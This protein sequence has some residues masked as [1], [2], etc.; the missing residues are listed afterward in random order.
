[1]R[2]LLAGE[3]PEMLSA[4]RVLLLY[5]YPRWNVQMNSRL[6]SLARAVRAQPCDLLIFDWHMVVRR[7]NRLQGEM[8]FLALRRQQPGLRIIVLDNAPD[9]REDVLRAGADAFVCKTDPP[10]SLLDLIKD[11]Q[12]IINNEEIDDVSKGK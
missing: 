11:I 5:L 7:K 2:V 4:L 9:N 8:L 6:S 12:L 1:M 10:E 3:N